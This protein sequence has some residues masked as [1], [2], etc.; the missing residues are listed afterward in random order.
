MSFDRDYDNTAELFGSSEDPL[1]RR[2]AAAI[3]RQRPALDLGV[4]QGRNALFLARA[5]MA[6]HG[7]DPSRVAVET[8]RDLA[9]SENLP[10]TAYQTSFE[11]FE[12]P[13]ETYSAVLAFGLLPLLSWAS[14][15][16]LVD[17]VEAWTAT[18]SLVLLTGFTTLDPRLEH[19]AAEGSRV[20]RNSF[21]LADG[22]LRTYLEPGEARALFPA[23]SVVHHWEGLGPEHRHGSGPPERHGMF[24]LVG[25]R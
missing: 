10:V 9:L 16:L 11:S 13:A 8:V 2:F 12:C 21:R 20:G 4:G 15:E 7:L 19:V 5:G 14:I 17:R 22:Q 23:L 1:L 25:R 24:E 18:G 6:V 3:D